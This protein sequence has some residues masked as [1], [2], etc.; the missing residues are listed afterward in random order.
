M[1]TA[2]VLRLKSGVVT[3]F[4]PILIEEGRAVLAGFDVE[5]E[6]EGTEG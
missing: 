4:I 6:V 1:F 5:L 2:D 3:G